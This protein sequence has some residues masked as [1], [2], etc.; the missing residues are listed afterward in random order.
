MVKVNQPV[1]FPAPR[2][3]VEDSSSPYF[4][5]NGDHPGL[6]LV[7]HPL[8][9][10]NYNTWFRAMNMALIAK[11]KLGFVD[12]SIPQPTSE[13]LLYGAWRRCNSMVI[14][15]ILNSVFREIA[16]SLMYIP[17][18]YEVW[19]DLRD[20]FHQ[21]NA[22]RIFQIK[23]LLNALQQGSLDVSAYYTRLRTLWD[24]LKEFQ[25]FPFVIAVL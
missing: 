9:G 22:P 6:V 8:S 20:R 15:W 4:L 2:P 14:S 21:S 3:V 7:S 5:H 12:G 17:T 19:I 10:N 24:E 13:D 11:N 18:V 23:R 16:D 25:P 1:V